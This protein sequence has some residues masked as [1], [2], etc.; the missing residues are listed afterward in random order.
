MK[1]LI[2][3]HRGSDIVPAEQQEN[4]SRQWGEWMGMLSEQS[5]VRVKG[6]R[7]VGFGSVQEYAGDSAGISIIEAPSA[8]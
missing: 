1:F 2:V 4:N 7:T 8:R 5:G 3:S 6:G